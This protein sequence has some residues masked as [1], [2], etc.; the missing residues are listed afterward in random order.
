MRIWPVFFV[1]AAT[2]AAAAQPAE[3]PLA[4]PSAQ[5]PE[6]ITVTA[7]PLPGRPA[8]DEFIY[9]YPHETR[10][11]EKIARWKDGICPMVDGIPARFGEFIIRR[12]KAIAQKAGAPVN[13]D[14]KCRHN[15]QILFTDQP[16]A[17]GDMLRKTRAPYLGYFDNLHQA[18]AL[19]KVTH[20][21]Q[22][23][24]L[25]ATVTYRGAWSIDD[26]RANFFNN[27][28]YGFTGGNDGNYV[29]FGATGG[30]LNN[31]IAS[32]LHNVIIVADSSKLKDYEMGSLA[33]YIAM[34]ALSRPKS[35]D[36]CWEV[37][38]ITNLLAK[39][40]EAERKP[41]TIS[42]ND[43]A[44][45]HGLYKMSTG[46]SIWSQRAEIRYFVERNKQR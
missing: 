2:A 19:A 21:V 22:A 27:G 41:L 6:S 40:C 36:A 16:Q 11:T 44:Y 3:K 23:W 33:D 1:L 26:P 8:V 37:P 45:L 42:D 9:S 4:P 10:R 28:N 7:T 35:F 34:L 38:S 12:M 30:R 17:V 25:T 20:D 24:Y 29:S 13:A 14:A 39:D 43:V 46:D 31:G 18:D 5:P 15:I 32:Y